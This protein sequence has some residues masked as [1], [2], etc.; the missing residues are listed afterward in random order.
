MVN[1]KSPVFLFIGDDKYLKEK[2][3][4]D[5]SASVLGG[6]SKDFDYKIFY[7]GETDAREAL[8]HINTI[9]F[10][11]AKRFV[12]IK[13]FEKISPEFKGRLINYIKKPSKSTCLVLEAADD[14]VLEEYGDMTKYLNVQV[15]K[16]PAAG[17]VLSWIKEFVRGR[18]KKMG[19]DAALLLKELQ[20]H[21]LLALTQELEK[22]IAF[23]GDREEISLSDVEE[24]VGRSLIISAFD[25]TRA[26]GEKNI[27]EAIR[28][29]S[30]LGMAGKKEFEI[31][32][33]LCWH[34]KRLLRAKALKARPES[35][36]LI[37][38]KRYHNEFFRQAS[39]LEVSQ[40]RSKIRILLEADLDIKRTGLSPHLIL[41]LAII[42]LCLGTSTAPGAAQ[43]QS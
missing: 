41:E 21:N 37:V 27:E 25:I 22:L 14:S 6:S 18:G 20:G 38:D 12:V 34:L 33:I 15:F 26:I 16:N 7:G 13:D 32:G 36:S 40:I 19:A 42:R 43:Y 39:G 17:E 5:L 1:P 30:D 31:I 23:A 10:L 2:A 29:S 3:I 24:M 4:K 28:I 9:P 11:A 35:I 8:E